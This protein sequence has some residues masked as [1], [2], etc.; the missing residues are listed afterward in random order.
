MNNAP[1]YINA[2]EQI[3]CQAPLCHS[4]IDSPVLL[5]GEGLVR[6]DDPNF[7]EYFPPLMSRKM[8]RLLKRAVVTSLAA[9]ERAA[10]GAPDAIVTGTGLG[11][12]ENTEAFLGQLVCD[13]EELL[14]PTHFMQSTH[15]TIGSTIAIH[16]FNHGYNATYSHKGISAEGAMLDAVTQMRLG[17][18]DTALVGCHDEVSA[19]YYTLLRKIGYV[20]VEGQCACT[21]ASVSLLLSHEPRGALCELVAT[22]LISNPDSCFWTDLF[23]RYGVGVVMTGI[24]GNHANDVCYTPVVQAACNRLQL[25]Y[26]HI[27]GENYSASALGL[28]ASAQAL[29][30]GRYPGDVVFP[31]SVTLAFINHSDGMTFSF[32]ILRSLM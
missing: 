10:L 2:A 20:G 1:I 32:T 17:D 25:A 5:E 22:G 13:G 11:C 3:S 4:W 18:I 12:V 21:E 24:S 19:T 7:R 26:K 27:F 15:N 31:P 28:Y 30:A 8:G 16:T 9:I 23:S 14:K 6:S 29:Q